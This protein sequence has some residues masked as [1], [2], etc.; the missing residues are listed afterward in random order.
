[1]SEF[2]FNGSEDLFFPLL[3]YLRKSRPG[4]NELFRKID[5]DEHE[6][7]AVS[8]SKLGIK[9]MFR[10]FEEEYGFPAGIL[11]ITPASN[12][13]TLVK[14]IVASEPEG[15]Q[16]GR[17]VNNDTLGIYE[18]EDADPHLVPVWITK[19]EGK[20]H[21]FIFD[22]LGHELS[23]TYSENFL[24]H[25]TISQSLMS[26]V[27]ALSD[28][29]EVG[30]N[31]VIYSYKNKR[32]NALVG[33]AIFS[34]NDLKNLVERHLDPTGESIL[35]FYASKPL[36]NLTARVAGPTS[37][38]TILELEFL[39]PDM[40]KITESLSVVERYLGL[41][42][43]PKLSHGFTAKRLDFSGEAL[44]E[45]QDIESL[46][47]SVRKASK[48]SPKGKR[49]NLNSTKSGLKIFVLLVARSFYLESKKTVDMVD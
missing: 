7:Y 47:E 12:L 17:I 46:T 19:A 9:S 27:L 40:M 4:I 23:E 14:K 33:C 8:L 2:V 5:M 18:G 37:R 26:L 45:T 41:S 1:M 43:M 24:S 32:Q 22:S 15:F 3:D 29:P 25:R 28:D 6:G 10:F 39:P 11:D 20:A 44:T 30:Q 49:Q 16:C 36:E 48:M 35:G 31:V 34:I 13:A 42:E 38:L 21:V